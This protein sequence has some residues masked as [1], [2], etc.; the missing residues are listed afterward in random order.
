MNTNATPIYEIALGTHRTVGAICI[1]LSLSTGIAAFASRQYIP[2]YCL[3]LFAVL[4]TIVI[5]TGGSI[6]ISENAIEHKNLFGRYRIAWSDI[7]RIEVGNAGT[8]IFHG[9]NK[10]FTCIPP[11]FWSGSQ[12]PDAVA[13][14]TRKLEGLNV[15]T[16]RTST[17]DYKMH[18]NVR[19]ID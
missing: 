1:I 8:L 10:R 14:L 16:Y 9:D 12:K 18:K 19:A 2:A 13:M 11:G 15:K 5:A 3:L 17:G 7:R 4:G 6:R